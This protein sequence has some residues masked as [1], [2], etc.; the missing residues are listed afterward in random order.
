M[1]MQTGRI[2]DFEDKAQLTKE[3]S[4]NP[5][6]VRL[7]R[8]ERRKL[9]AYDEASRPAAL[10]SLRATSKERNKAKAARKARRAQ[11]GK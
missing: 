6:L 4:E 9:A 5:Y 1:D 11:R 10:V 3:Q 2:F 7:S 8:A